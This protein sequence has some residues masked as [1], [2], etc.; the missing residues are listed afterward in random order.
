M[1]ANIRI[2]G[3]AGQGIETTGEA[4]VRSFAAMGLWVFST[5]S[6]MSRVRGGLNW[7]DVRVGDHELSSGREEADL[8]IA[9][10]ERGAGELGP[11]VRDGGLLLADGET[12]QQDAVALPFTDT[13]KGEADAK[14]MANVVAAGAAF[15]VL[16]YDLEALCDHL[17]AAFQK[18]GEQVVDKN[19]RCA[20]RG[21]ELAAGWAGS[22]QAPQ[23]SGAPPF[24]S[25]GSEAVGLGA[26]ACG[27]KLVTAYPMTPSTAAF[28]VLAQAADRYGI[29]VEQ[30]E[31]EIAAI[32]MVCGAAYAG[33]PAMTAT[34]GG[35][36][37]LM[38]E[39]LSLAGMLE[40]P[41]FIML[42]Q[43]PD[44]LRDC[45]R[46]RPS[47]TCGSCWGPATASSRGPSMRRA[48]RARRAS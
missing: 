13:A 26:A 48:A 41:V 16:G 25:D 8:L 34:S 43:R 14:I 2:A 5:R 31:D 4:L 47:R 45:P 19:L 18:K 12:E 44:R 32:N 37:A 9:L 46:A 6:Y 22:L 30:A 20:R 29:V 17:K 39:G 7:F 42:A 23:P 38:C 1:D 21:A 36:F 27:V 15:A 28:T 40:L 24:C 11:R 10:S 3:E 35:G 33:V